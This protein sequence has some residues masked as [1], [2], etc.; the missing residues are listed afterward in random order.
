MSSF[1]TVLLLLLPLTIF[2]VGAA[3]ILRT[4]SPI[5]SQI[6]QTFAI[7]FA[8]VLVY[9]VYGILRGSDLIRVSAWFYFFALSIEVVVLYSYTGIISLFVGKP[10]SFP[11]SIYFLGGSL[12]TTFGISLRLIRWIKRTMQ[13]RLPLRAARI[14]RIFHEFY[15]ESR[16]S[17][18]PPDLAF[19]LI[20]LSALLYSAMSTS[21]LPSY[22]FEPLEILMTICLFSSIIVLVGG[23]VAK[24][25]ALAG[26]WVTKKVGGGGPPRG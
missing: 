7:T 25:I 19:L 17:Y 21:A 2:L 8:L 3:S 13:R 1:D 9:L 20:G 14:E 22:L 10:V 4:Q 15:K 16:T 6:S 26:E 24:K 11:I 18:H 23:W 12:C 5:M